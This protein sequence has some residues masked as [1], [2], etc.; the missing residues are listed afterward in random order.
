MYMYQTSIMNVC[1]LGIP[2]RRTTVV[3]FQKEFK[4]LFIN[5]WFTNLDSEAIEL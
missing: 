5:V 3:P 1:N 4:I 2:K